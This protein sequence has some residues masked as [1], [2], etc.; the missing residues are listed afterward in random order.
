MLFIFVLGHNGRGS[1]Q[2]F[3]CVHSKSLLHHSVIARGGPGHMGHVVADA[4]I[5]F[6]GSALIRPGRS[7]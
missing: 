6:M 7:A 5:P 3:P 2:W 1:K 4:W